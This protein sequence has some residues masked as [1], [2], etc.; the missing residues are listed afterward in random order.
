AAD[1]DD[2][3]RPGLFFL[4]L[5]LP[6]FG[7]RQF[8]ANDDL[9][10]FLL[11]PPARHRIECGRPEPLACAQAETGVMPGTSHGVA[12]DEAIDEWSFVV[13]A[14][15]ADGEALTALLHHQYLGV[16]HLA[17]DLAGVP[18]LGGRNA[19]RQVRHV[20]TFGVF[21]I[22]SLSNRIADGLTRDR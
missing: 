9:P 15:G 8:F 11:H 10:V 21:H 18:Q 13:G 19:P 2:R 17:D 3:V 20:I 4:G 7:V 16:T 5:R 14:V 1:D 22:D 12:D 6:L